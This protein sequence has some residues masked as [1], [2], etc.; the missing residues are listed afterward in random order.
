MKTELLRTFNCGIGMIV[1][2]D[3]AHADAVTAQLKDAG[4]TVHTVGQ[5]QEEPQPLV[6]FPD[7][8]DHDATG[9]RC[10]SFSA[11]GSNMQRLAH[12]LASHLLAASLFW[13]SPTVRRRVALNFAKPKVSPAP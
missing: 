4:E 7:K 11:R 2:V 5:L 10:H 3:A 1:V 9:S 12:H 13:P 8:S 6:T